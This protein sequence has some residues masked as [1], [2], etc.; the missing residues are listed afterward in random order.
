MLHIHRTMNTLSMRSL[1]LRYCGRGQPVRFSTAGAGTGAASS[2]NSSND[3]VITT[4]NET[5]GIAMLT[6]NRPPANSLSLEMLQQLY[7]DMYGSRLAIVA[8]IQGH[9]PA[10]GCFLAMAC[11]YRIMSAGDMGDGGNSDMMKKFVP[12]IGL[13]ETQLGI[14]GECVLRRPGFFFNGGGGGFVYLIAINTKIS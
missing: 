10:A 3:L 11:D 9:A 4:V 5:S 12:T 2:N 7:L 6:M 8:A 14:A 1:L 13:N